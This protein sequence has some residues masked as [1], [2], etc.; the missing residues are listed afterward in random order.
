LKMLAKQDLSPTK[1]YS[2]NRNCMEYLSPRLIVFIL[3]PEDFS[4]RSTMHSQDFFAVLHIS[5]TLSLR[6]FTRLLRT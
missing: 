4:E 3:D 1:R 2:R 5:Y 6:P